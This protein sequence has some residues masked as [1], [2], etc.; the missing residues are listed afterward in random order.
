MVG[1]PGIEPGVGHPGGVTVPCRTLQPVARYNASSHHK[2]GL[3][4]RAGGYR[5]HKICL[6]RADVRAKCAANLE[7]T[8]HGTQKRQKTRV[9]C[10]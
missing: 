7:R 4:S 10:W 2:L 5:Q 6:L 3:I 9:G 1:D 8:A